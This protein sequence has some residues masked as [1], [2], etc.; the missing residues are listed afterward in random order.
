MV[1]TLAEA[2]SSAMPNAGGT[3]SSPVQPEPFVLSLAEAAAEAG[4]NALGE[5]YQAKDEMVM[6]GSGSARHGPAVPTPSVQL[7]VRPPAKERLAQHEVDHPL[8]QTTQ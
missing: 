5:W 1:G 4:G 3:S 2:V 6:Q 8:R 7:V